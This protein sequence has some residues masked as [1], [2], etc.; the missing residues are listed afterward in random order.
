MSLW[1]VLGLSQRSLSVTMFR[2]FLWSP[3]DSIC[4]QAFSSPLSRLSDTDRRT[5]SR[6][7]R[8]RATGRDRRRTHVS[9]HQAGSVSRSPM[10]EQQAIHLACPLYYSLSIAGARLTVQ[11]TLVAKADHFTV[12]RIPDLEQ[13]LAGSWGFSTIW[14]TAKVYRES[15]DSY[16]QCNCHLT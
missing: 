12:P 11:C 10:L 9:G 1:W 13:S 8:S 15:G 2:G 3:V 5:P 14:R 6:S 4:G 16:S 7:R